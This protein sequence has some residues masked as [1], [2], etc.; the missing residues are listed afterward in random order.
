MQGWDR[1]LSVRFLGQGGMGQVFLA[2]DPRLRRE[3]AIKFVRGDNPEHVRRLI[4]EAR[5]QARV[6]HEHVRE[7]ERDSLHELLRREL[8]AR[9]HRRPGDHRRA[10][11]VDVQE[12]AAR[13]ARGEAQRLA[14]DERIAERRP[15]GAAGPREVGGVARH[16]DRAAGEGEHDAL[17]SAAEDRMRDDGQRDGEADIGGTA[18]RADGRGDI[19]D[20]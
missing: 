14:T 7:L 11:G 16:A 20:R 18:A 10:A 9:C 5:T 6:N 15:E 2:V 13:G 17:A 4:A 19:P 3:V 1:Y 12:D 8:G